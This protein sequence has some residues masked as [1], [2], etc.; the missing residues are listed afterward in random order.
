[1]AQCKNRH[2][3]VCLFNLLEG[4]LKALILFR[5][6]LGELHHEEVLAFQNP[7]SYFKGPEP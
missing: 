2:K 4:I 1:M 3:A 5:G 7:I 6:I